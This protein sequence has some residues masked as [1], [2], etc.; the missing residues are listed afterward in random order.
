MAK[1][2]YMKDEE[3]NDVETETDDV[4]LVLPSMAYKNAFAMLDD[5]DLKPAFYKDYLFLV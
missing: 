1:K 3:G 5:P 2:V 4:Q